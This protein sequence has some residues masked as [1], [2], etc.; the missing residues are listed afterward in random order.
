[1]K[2]YLL[3]IILFFTSLLSVAQTATN[4]TCNDCDG[5]SHTLFDDLDAGKVIVIC[6]VMPCGAC[7]GGAL[8]SYN[9]VQSYALS[10]PNTVH[11]YLCDDYANTACSSIN[12]WANT[13]GLTN[14]IRFSNA[15][16]NMNHYGSTGMPKVVVVGGTNH[17]VFYN[18]NNSINSTNLQNAINAALTATG[19]NEQNNKASALTVFPNPSGN[20]AEVKFNLVKSSNVILELFN[21]EGKY[22]GNIFT[23]NLNAGDNKIKVN[24]D[25]VAVGMYLIKFSDGVHQQFTN[26]VK[27]K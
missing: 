26:L 24:L 17:T 4:F 9:V 11:M 15:S 16:I 1:M 7:V 13:N 23:G 20:S 8:T 12:S 27:E 5:N 18:T 25:T 14:T 3:S 22:I 10:N 19:I 6:W 21:L 2:K